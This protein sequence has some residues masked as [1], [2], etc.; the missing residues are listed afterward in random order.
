MDS[1]LLA[2]HRAGRTP[3]HSTRTAQGAKS[4]SRFAER[5]PLT[6]H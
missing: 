3:A 5:P 2:R 4:E 1:G 6:P